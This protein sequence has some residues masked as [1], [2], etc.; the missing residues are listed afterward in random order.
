MDSSP[1]VV[2]Q[3]LYEGQL[4]LQQE[5]RQEAAVASMM[6][7][8]VQLMEEAAAPGTAHTADAAQH[9]QPAELEAAR[10]HQHSAA[11]VSSHAEQ[12]SSHQISSHVNPAA[13]VP[14]YTQ[15]AVMPSTEEVPRI[16]EQQ[17][18]DIRGQ[19]YPEGSTP[20][21]DLHDDAPQPPASVFSTT[22][23]AAARG[24]QI[25]KSQVTGELQGVMTRT[26]S[27][28]LI[29]QLMRERSTSISNLGIILESGNSGS[30]HMTLSDDI[31]RAALRKPLPGAASQQLLEP[32][33]DSFSGKSLNH[34]CPVHQ[35]IN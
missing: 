17:P 23:A 25:P 2:L 19:A 32:L 13:A 6:S 29:E 20:A 27:G 33:W 10:V 26:P 15:A 16:I 34:F 4:Q 35:S 1:Q 28:R 31:L 7:P 5:D 8:A 9:S 12:G 14:Q 11:H 18:A 30:L 3:T 21:A 24:E 22:A